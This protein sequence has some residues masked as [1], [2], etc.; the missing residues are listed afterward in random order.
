MGDMRFEELDAT[1]GISAGERVRVRVEI[2]PVVD[3][4][5]GARKEYR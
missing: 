5:S 2:C 1:R 3:T 4:N